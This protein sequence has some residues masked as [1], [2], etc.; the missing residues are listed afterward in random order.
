MASP[1]E[2]AIRG[3]PE[4]QTPLLREPRPEHNKEAST[5]DPARLRDGPQVPAEGT[6]CTHTTEPLTS[7]LR[8]AAAR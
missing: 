6:T 1:A 7:L 8:G 2:F 5:F 3:R 4:D